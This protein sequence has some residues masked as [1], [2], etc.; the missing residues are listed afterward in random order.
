MSRKRTVVVFKIRMPMPE[1]G[2]HVT[3]AEVM[4]DMIFPPGTSILVVEMPVSEWRDIASR[5]EGISK[6]ANLNTAL[7]EAG[8]DGDTDD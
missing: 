5:C 1:G 8:P 7:V 3:W 6:L 2:H 4:P